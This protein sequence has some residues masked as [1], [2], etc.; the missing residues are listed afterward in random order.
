L[1][2]KYRRKEVQEFDNSVWSANEGKE[3]RR[4]IDKERKESE[5]E[6]QIEL[7]REKKEVLE[8][9]QIKKKG[10][11]VQQGSRRGGKESRAWEGAV[12]GL[13]IQAPA[14]QGKKRWG[15]VAAYP[16]E[17]IQQL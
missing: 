5:W 17:Q 3:G 8:G 11:V 12:V 9:A 6:L 10:D 1:R 16:I 2:L 4:A 14:C 7:Y 15:G 13:A